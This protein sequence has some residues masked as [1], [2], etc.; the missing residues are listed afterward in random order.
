MIPELLG[1][2]A[3]AALETVARMPASARAWLA[4]QLKRRQPRRGR[5]SSDQGA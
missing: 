4:R 3:I 5:P 1:R 2:A